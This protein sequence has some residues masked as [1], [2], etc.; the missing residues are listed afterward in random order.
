MVDAEA[1]LP[2]KEVRSFRSQLITILRTGE[3]IRQAF[4]LADILAP[5]VSMRTSRSS[6]APRGA[7]PPQRRNL[8]H[9]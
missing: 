9:D 2:E 4:L 1:I 5:P 8:E 6:L 7:S 3:G